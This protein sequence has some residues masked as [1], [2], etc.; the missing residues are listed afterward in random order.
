LRRH[1]GG[2]IS[3]PI[4]TL[5]LAYLERATVDVDISHLKPLNFAATETRQKHQTDD[6]GIPVAFKGCSPPTVL[7]E[8]EDSFGGMAR[9]ETRIESTH[10]RR[11]NEQHGIGDPIMA[12]LPPQDRSQAA[13]VR[14]DCASTQA[15]AA[16]LDDPVLKDRLLSFEIPAQEVFDGAMTFQE[17]SKHP[18]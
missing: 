2:P 16:H 6:R 14:I 7:H 5:S 12:H 3:T 18:V 11:R 8:R 13:P 10:P 15:T 17:G 1:V 4:R 9:Q